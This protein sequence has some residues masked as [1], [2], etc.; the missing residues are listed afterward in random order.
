MKKETKKEATFK[1]LPLGDRV[2]IKESDK[3]AGGETKSGIIIPETVTEDKGSKKGIVIA[4][5]EGHYVDGKL[6][7][8][9][10]KVGEKVLF[11]WGDMLK[12]DGEEYYMVS[13][14]SVL[15]VVK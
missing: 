9:S 15:A 12:I 13:E 2:L 10:V 14:S 4:I 8:I 3:E 1:V 5:G 7:P 6:I 11:Q